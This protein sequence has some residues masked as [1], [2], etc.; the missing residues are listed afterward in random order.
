MKSLFAIN[1]IKCKKRK[2]SCVLL[3]QGWIVGGFCWVGL[4]RKIQNKKES[5]IEVYRWV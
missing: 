5:L 3:Y 2:V 4:L 1:K